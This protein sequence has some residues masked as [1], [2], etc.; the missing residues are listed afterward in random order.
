MSSITRKREI[1]PL[2]G[3]PL[4]RMFWSIISDYGLRTGI[5]ELVD[6]AIDLWMIAGCKKPLHINIDLNIRQQIIRVTDNAGGVKKEDLALLVAP[7][8]SRNDPDNA[9]IGIFGV[10]GKRA[11][12]ALGERVNIKT[13]AG[14]ADTYEIEITPEWLKSDDWHLPYSEVPDV[15]I[16]TTE[17]EISHLR[18]VLIK[19]DIEDIQTH[20]GETYARFLKQGCTIQ[21]NESSPTAPLLF[22]SWSYPPGQSPKRATFDVDLAAGEMIKATITGGLISDRDPKIENYGVYFYCNHRLIVKE[23]RERQVG[24]NVSSEA[25]VPHPDASLC[26][27]IVELEGAAKLMPW[28]SSKS[29]INY[30][31]SAF[32]RTRPTIIQLVTH[33]SSLS[34]RLKNDWKRQVFQFDTGTIQEIEPDD[35]ALKNP[36]VLPPLPKVRKKPIE[37]LKA[38]NKRIL[39]NKPWT[40]GF[41]ESMAAID[42]VTHQHYETKNRIALLLLDSNFEIA[43]KE[44]VVHEDSLFPKKK[45]NTTKL[46][47]LFANRTDVI[48]EITQHLSIPPELI[49]KA[50]HYYGLRNKLIHERV[51]VDVTEAD[52]RSYRMTVEK[53]LKLLFGLKF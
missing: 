7:G 32:E 52:I 14:R 37:K 16:S 24:Y 50:K 2:D 19:D 4:K 43:L 12:V 28:N 45:Y 18:R 46:E 17:V 3:T 53:I 49:S 36:L 39:D 6:N 11:G 30:N 26:R 15:S 1:G 13:R 8:G 33:F 51:T 41:L 44:F 10:G 29:G 38:K 5:C 34:R 20:I 48:R 31:H 9:V 23:L 40:L 35:S 42:I 47:S 21:V 22:E 27:V 25:G